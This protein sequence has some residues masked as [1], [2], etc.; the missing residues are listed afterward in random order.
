MIER[1]LAAFAIVL[2]LTGE[3]G[4]EPMTWT[5]LTG[6]GR[7]GAQLEIDAAACDI[8]ADQSAAGQPAAAGPNI[9]LTIANIGTQMILKQNF[10]ELCLLS[11]GWKRVP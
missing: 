9:G 1:S 2:L 4:A 8:M 7:G 6:A 10:T 11:K 3:S 5:D